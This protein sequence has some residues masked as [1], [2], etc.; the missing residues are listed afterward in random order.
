[1]SGKN[2][3]VTG[4]CG[5]IGSNFIH[6]A[7]RQ[8]AVPVR[9]LVNL[10][11]LTYAGSVENLAGL[12][13]ARY[14]LVRGD[15]NDGPLTAQLL[16]AYQ[17]DTVLNFAAESHVDRAIDEPAPFVQANVVG[18][19]RLLESA[20]AYYRSLSGRRREDFRVVQ[21]STDEVYGSLDAADGGFTETARYAP[22]NPYAASKA[23]ADHF[24]RSFHRTYGLPLLV[25]HCSNNYGPRQL[26]EKLIPLLILNARAGLP[27]PVYG[28]GANVRDWIYVADYAA[29]LLALLAGGRVGESY[30][31]GGGQELANLQ[32]AE[33][34]C[35]LMDAWQ[36]LAG[37]GTRRALIRLVADRPGHDFRYAM[38]TGKVR[39]ELGWRPSHDFAGGIEK[40]AR[41]YLDQ[42]AWRADAVR[43][44][45]RLRRD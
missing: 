37:G 16:R 17:I 22:S 10:D 4:G 31:F 42:P 24:A 27:L 23:A 35:D 43:Y 8:A 19:V 20:L 21:I 6:A 39:A 38:N 30:H 25:S 11:A 44:E 32:V 3:L 13:D 26:P 40:T 1:M 15:I 18:A 34:I 29:G 45:R 5:F 12:D 28:S 41:W 14:V 7:L 9:T 33:K 2:I 36:P